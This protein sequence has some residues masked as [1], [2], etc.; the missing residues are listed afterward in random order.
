M[1]LF[2]N[3]YK[4]RYNDVKKTYNNLLKE[5]RSKQYQ[6]R[7]KKTDNKSKCMWSIVNEI[8]GK[9]RSKNEIIIDADPQA[10][11]H[12]FNNFFV[13][14]GPNLVKSLKCSLN[15]N[16]AYSN[17]SIFVK[18]LSKQELLDLARII[19]PKMSCGDDEVP[20]LIIN[21]CIRQISAPLCFIINNSLKYGI[22]PE[23]LKSA[24]VKPIYKGSGDASSFDSYRPIS[25]LPSFSKI[26]EVIVCSRLADFLLENG[27]VSTSQ[28]GFVRG[29]STQ[30]AIYS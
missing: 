26:F 22:F 13:N 24:L 3:S 6:S 1:K 12:S 29:R 19:K 30:S 20:T 10:L 14:V 18:P 28:H 5:A 16:I 4:Q 21:A 2:D 7:F 11:A 17:R 27:V 23:L 15:A 25:V 9:T 8:K